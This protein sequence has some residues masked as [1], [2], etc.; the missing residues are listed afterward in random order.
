MYKRALDSS[1]NNQSKP[2]K[3]QKTSNNMICKI[4]D[5][6]A[7]GYNY[8]ILSCASCKIFFRRNAHLDLVSLL[9]FNFDF[10]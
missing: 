8:D 6:H 1:D 9:F 10:M 7:I 5:D 4:C 2:I 3:T